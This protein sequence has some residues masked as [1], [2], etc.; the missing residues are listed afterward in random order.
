MKRKKW[1]F[2]DI[3]RGDIYLA[4]LGNEKEVRG[5]EQFG[6]RPVLVTQCNYNN[7]K[8][9]TIIVAAVTSE[10]KKEKMDCHLILP[11]Q[12]GLPLQ[13]M[14]LAEQRRAIDRSRLI[15]YCCTVDKE[16]MDKVFRA[17]KRAEGA[18]KKRRRW[19]KTIYLK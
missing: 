12:S 9:P 4:D 7:R 8:S 11:S 1:P 19:R 14:V 16:T 2:L 13:S 5:S 18:E 17:C 3:E 6:I 10:I 15:R